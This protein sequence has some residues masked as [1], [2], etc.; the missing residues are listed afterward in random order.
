LV[1]PVVDGNGILYAP[2]GGSTPGASDGSPG[3]IR[4]DCLDDFAYRNIGFVG[5]FTRG[6]EMFVFKDVTPRLSI[7]EAA[8]TTIPVGAPGPVIVSLPFGSPTNQVVRL[9]ST[10]F[11]AAT[12]VQVTVTP[13]TGPSLTFEQPIPANIGANP[14]VTGVDVVIP[15]GAISQIDAW[16]R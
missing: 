9:Q 4:I 15:A 3:R 11:A 5:S 10:G 14:L 2:G 16:T 8:G 7:V 12:R 6:S 1:A 13:D